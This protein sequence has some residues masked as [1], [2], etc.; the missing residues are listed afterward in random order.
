MLSG[1]GR[2]E[3]YTVT[4]FLLVLGNRCVKV[5]QAGAQRAYPEEGH[6][7]P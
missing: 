1:G 4:G 3:V 6:N 7:W 2:Q 5:A